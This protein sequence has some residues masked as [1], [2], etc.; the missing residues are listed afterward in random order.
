[1]PRVTSTPEDLQL[2]LK[3]NG[4]CQARKKYA[5]MTFQ[6]AWGHAYEHERKWAVGLLV[7]EGAI[8]YP[9]PHVSANCPIC[10]PELINPETIGFYDAEVD[11]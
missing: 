7:E 9:L 2:W 10:N 1:M 3:H 6:Q 8:P 4:A 5:G 11:E